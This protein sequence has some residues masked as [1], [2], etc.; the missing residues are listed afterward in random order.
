MV[1]FEHWTTNKKFF[2]HSQ[3]SDG[4]G[5]PN[6][7]IPVEYNSSFLLWK[8]EPYTYHTFIDTNR[9]GMFYKRFGP[10]QPD[11]YDTCIYCLICSIL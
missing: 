10:S 6:L 1:S 8:S 11:R 4:D 2:Y 7:I 5:D 9:R 3:L